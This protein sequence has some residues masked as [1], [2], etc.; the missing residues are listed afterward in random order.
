MI[1]AQTGFI[2]FTE[3]LLAVV[4]VWGWL[5]YYYSVKSNL[6][7]INNVQY[8]IFTLSLVSSFAFIFL[9]IILFLEKTKEVNIIVHFLVIIVSLVLLILSSIILN[10]IKFNSS[11]MTME[12]KYVFG[13]S[14]ITIIFG[15]FLL[16][17][18]L[19]GIICE[20]IAAKSMKKQSIS[21]LTKNEIKDYINTMMSN[22]ENQ[23]IHEDVTIFP[24]KS[25]CAEMIPENIQGINDIKIMRNTP[26]N[27]RLF[28][29]LSSRV[30]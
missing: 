9:L 24:M 28:K 30:S 17:S 5:G 1:V 7:N 10:K 13:C 16:V 20:I 6:N 26:E 14:I 21:D 27:S 29:K 15:V 25:K 3:F 23:N 11:N 8:E 4:I 22:F 18:G 2:V 19:Y 12:D